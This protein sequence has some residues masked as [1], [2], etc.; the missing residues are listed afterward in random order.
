MQS[1]VKLYFCY[2]SS[3]IL[4]NIIDRLTNKVKT[5][6]KLLKTRLFYTKAH[7]RNALTLEIISI[8]LLS[9]VQA[10]TTKIGNFFSPNYLGTSYDVYISIDNHG[11][12]V[13]AR[14]FLRNLY[15]FLEKMLMFSSFFFTCSFVY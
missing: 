5:S 14:R 2:T 13:F 7:E 3:I 11:K 10:L 12:Q 15:P 8:R 4:Y 6:Q 9:M 1:N